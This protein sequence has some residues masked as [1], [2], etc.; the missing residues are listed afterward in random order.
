MHSSG[1]QQVHHTKWNHSRWYPVHHW[2][3]RG[4]WHLPRWDV[5]EPNDT[6]HIL[7]EGVQETGEESSARACFQWDVWLNGD[8]YLKL[9]WSIY[10]STCCTINSVNA[11]GKALKI[12]PYNNTIC[13][14]QPTSRLGTWMVGAWRAR[15][16]P[17]SKKAG[18]YGQDSRIQIKFQGT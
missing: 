13:L 7:P 3:G 11:V 12:M 10:I 17:R 2:C 1:L 15:T 5:E 14:H 4:G 18:A 16:S 9:N 6:G 8:I